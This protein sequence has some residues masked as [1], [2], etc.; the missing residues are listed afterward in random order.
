MFSKKYFVNPVSL[1]VVFTF[2]I[3]QSTSS[4]AAPSNQN[5]SHS[6]ESGRG[7][8]STATFYRGKHSKVGAAEAYYLELWGEWRDIRSPF[9][10][11]SKER[12][13][14]RKSICPKI[15]L[16]TNAN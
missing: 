7:N 12:K 4:D 9:I 16:H 15:T 11:I 10:K 14:E 1:F 5:I 2:V 6:N 8:H 13:K 3:I